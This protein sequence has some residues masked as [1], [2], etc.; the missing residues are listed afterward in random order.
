MSLSVDAALR[1][2][3]EAGIGFTAIKGQWNLQNLSLS[4]PELIRLS[5]ILKER[6][7]RPPSVE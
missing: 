3:R 4:S 6:P 2:L 1:I 5:R 7:V